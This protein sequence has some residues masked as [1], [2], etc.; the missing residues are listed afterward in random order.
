MATGGIKLTPLEVILAG[1]NVII[2]IISIAVIFVP[3]L[4]SHVG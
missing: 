2:A 3:G 1:A 4:L